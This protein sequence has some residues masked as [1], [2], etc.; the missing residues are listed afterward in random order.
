MENGII[1]VDLGGTNIRVGLV[2]NQ[3]IKKTK[4]SCKL[5]KRKRTEICSKLSRQIYVFFRE[6]SSLKWANPPEQR[7]LQTELN[8]Y[9][10]E[11]F[12]N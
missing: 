8:V 1:A 12:L 7:G 5:K 10:W 6:Y 4:S 9:A 11:K 3:K 2:E